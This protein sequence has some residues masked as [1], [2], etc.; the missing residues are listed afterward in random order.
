MV[1]P[2]SAPATLTPRPDLPVTAV[3]P[4]ANL[5]YA[6]QILRPSIFPSKKYYSIEGLDDDDEEDEKAEFSQA[7]TKPVCMAHENWCFIYDLAPLQPFHF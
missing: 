7:Q 6:P 5:P 3:P 2:A 1:P 4:N